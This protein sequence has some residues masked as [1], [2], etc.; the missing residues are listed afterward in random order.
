MKKRGRPATTLSAA[1]LVSLLFSVPAV[2]AAATGYVAGLRNFPLR[3]TPQFSASPIARLPVGTRVSILEEKDGW[4]RVK[5]GEGQG[6]MPESVI[7][8]ETPAAVQ[9]GPLQARVKETDARFEKISRENGELKEKNSGLETRVAVLEGELEEVEDLVSG[10]RTSRRLQGMAL[11]GG[12][13]LFGWLTG[14]AL[15]SRSGQARSKGK[16]IID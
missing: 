13:V 2:Q 1:L 7:S 12:L 11:G 4:V 3:D 14:Y 5:T 16:L 10:A 6:W 8:E 9:L 15:A